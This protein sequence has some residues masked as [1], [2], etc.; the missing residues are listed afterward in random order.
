V[1]GGSGGGMPG[2]GGW[3][4]LAVGRFFFS[5][6]GLAKHQLNRAPARVQH[7]TQATVDTEP[8]VPEAGAAISHA[9][10]LRR[11]PLTRMRS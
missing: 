1:P 11:G 10:R 5:G 2:N 6:R 3:T 8:G 7:Q 4:G 9:L